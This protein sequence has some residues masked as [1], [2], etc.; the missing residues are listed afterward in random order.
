MVEEIAIRF[1]NPVVSIGGYTKRLQRP[2][3]LPKGQSYLDQ[4]VHE[5]TRLETMI[6]VWK[7]MSIFETRL[8]KGEHA[9][10]CRNG[11]SI[12]F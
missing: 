4:I 9:R 2:S 3:I 11:A 7:N 10:G 6:D 5:T 8:W 1:A 12:L